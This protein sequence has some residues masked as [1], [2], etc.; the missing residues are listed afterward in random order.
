MDRREF[1]LNQVRGAIWLGLSAAG[2]SVPGR[3]LASGEPDVAVVKGSRVKA[4]RAA[5]EL[6]GGMKK[7]VKPGNR[8]LI[9]PNMSFADRPDRATNTH[10][11]VVRELVI[12]CREAGASRV[13]VLDHTL[14]SPKRCLE[15][16]GI[17]DALKNVDD[18]IVHAVNNRKFFKDTEL[19]EGQALSKTS[20]MA[21]ALKRDVLIAAPVAKSHGATGVSLSMK[22]MMGLVYNRR[23][24][25][26]AYD[27]DESIVDLCTVLKADLAVIDASRVLSTN[28]PGG[29]GRVLKEN[30]IIASKDM[31]AADACAVSMFEWY[32]RRFKP[33]QVQHIQLAHE[34]G[35]GRMDL[36]NLNIK[37]ITI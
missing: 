36:E 31:V 9:K 3:A 10:P 12:M 25:H 24:M 37:K 28:G 1:F 29:P 23:V 15:N 26:W 17:Y 13:R 32:G 33:R 35:L 16:S 6:V 30:T 8:V 21:D 7:Y 27:L 34:R 19:P 20:I 14:N 5:V 18:Q 22:G 11:E 4:V 2:L